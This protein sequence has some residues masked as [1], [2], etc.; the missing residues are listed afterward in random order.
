MK[1]QF[2]YWTCKF[3]FFFALVFR[4]KKSLRSLNNILLAF[5]S[6]LL[7]LRKVLH[8]QLQLYGS[9]DCINFYHH[10]T[11]QDM[12]KMFHFLSNESGAFPTSQCYCNLIVAIVQMR[13]AHIYCLSPI[14][15]L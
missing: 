2:K 11:F 1:F 5:S 3:V 8:R 7:H 13:N 9:N 12:Q 6:V 10:I 4:K 15:C 14:L